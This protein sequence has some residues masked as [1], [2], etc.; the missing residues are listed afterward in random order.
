MSN[1]IVPIRVTTCCGSAN[2]TVI[3]F[4]GNLT[5]SFNFNNLINDAF[6]IE[7]G[8]PVSNNVEHNLPWFLILINVVPLIYFIILC[9]IWLIVI[10]DGDDDVDDL[11]DD[12]DDIDVEDN[13]DDVDD[14]DEDDDDDEVDAEDE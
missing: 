12:D 9:F 4:D 7:W 13:E 8:A 5:L 6:T 14:K 11:D 2:V 3:L 1:I 10:I